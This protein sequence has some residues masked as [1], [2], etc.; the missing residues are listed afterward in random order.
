MLD[1]GRAYNRSIGRDGED[2]SS[3]A[4]VWTQSACAVG[5]NVRVRDVH[6]RV[7]LLWA[8]D[9]YWMGE[10]GQRCPGFSMGNS[11]QLHSVPMVINRDI[12]AFPNECNFRA[13]VIM[14]TKH[15][16]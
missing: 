1:Q 12:R 5:Q 2:A 8:K 13:F 15:E 3:N 7:R 6:A 14:Q 10:S 16:F 11:M 9:L 4:R